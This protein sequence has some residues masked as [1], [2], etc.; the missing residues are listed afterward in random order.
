MHSVGNG[1]QTVVPRSCNYAT[2][3]EI[4]KMPPDSHRRTYVNNCFAENEK[5]RPWF[6]AQRTAEQTQLIEQV[7]VRLRAMMPFLKPVSTDTIGA[8]QT[9]G[10][11]R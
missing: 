4:K 11:A 7:G 6:N 5:G 3:A 2:R 10:N 1:N 8:P 9:V